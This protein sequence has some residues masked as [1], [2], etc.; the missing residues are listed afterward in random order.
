M[1]KEMII[2]DEYHSEW[3]GN[4]IYQVMS[5]AD[6]CNFRSLFQSKGIANIPNM[7]LPARTC[8]DSGL[9]TDSD[10]LDEWLDAHR[11]EIVI[12]E[13]HRTYQD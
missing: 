10:E 5:Y 1:V 12:K 13:D 3:D 6:Y 9:F 2:I 7:I 8:R 4:I 11:D